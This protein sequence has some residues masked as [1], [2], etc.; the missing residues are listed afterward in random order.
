M[1][2]W[3]LSIPLFPLYYVRVVDASDAW[4]GLINT[5]QSAVLLVGYFLW[6]RESQLRGS[7][8]VL[9]WTTLGLC[10]HPA[11]V[12]S[13]QRVE[14]ILVY[15]GFAGIF[16]AGL[17]LVFFDELM[18]TVPPQYSATFV[19]LAQSMQHFS[20]VLAPL[21]GTALAGWIGIGGALLVSTGIRLAGF[22]LFAFWHLRGEEQSA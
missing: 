22:G 16:Q 12:A 17:D 19:S 11:L 18:K 15:A 4:I 1:S 2:G 21:I 5:V 20:A 13:T 6:T 7:R 8:F 9:L 3:M 14:M 10:L